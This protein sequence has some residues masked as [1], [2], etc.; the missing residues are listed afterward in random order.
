VSARLWG[1]LAVATVAVVVAA[2]YMPQPA[3]AAQHRDYD[4]ADFSSQ[5]EAQE[6]LSPGDPYN[7]DGDSDGIACEDNPCPC[8]T[9][10]GGETKPGPSTILPPP[11][12]PKLNKGAAKRAAK[13]K[14]R[15]FVSRSSRVST[16]SFAGCSRRN[17]SKI[18]CRFV[19]KGER[20]LRRTVCRLRVK[21]RGEASFA[22]A[23]LRPSCRSESTLFLS[24]GRA[25]GA[26][27][28][29]GAEL[30][31][32]PIVLRGLRRISDLSFEGAAEWRR[33]EPTPAECFAEFVVRLL[34]TN[35]L[36]VTHT[37]VECMPIE[38]PR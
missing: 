5:A 14:A 32:R 2:L 10:S 11:K 36:S 31:E 38:P 4:C 21:V 17:R 13:A 34:R 33:T 15:R 27:R 26:I 19:A 30:A 8:K 1:S 22:S 25:S 18:V 3:A 23:S 35:T 9:G 28:E 29:Y 24:A 6:Y 12:P 16:L 20:D 37:G 7:L